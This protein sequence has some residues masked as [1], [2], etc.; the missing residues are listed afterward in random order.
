[1][2]GILPDQQSIAKKS[3]FKAFFDKPFVI[4]LIHDIRSFFGMLSMVHLP[5]F[6]PNFQQSSEK[7]SGTQSDFEV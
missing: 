5:H 4:I 1:M 6:M 7:R 2:G 3:I